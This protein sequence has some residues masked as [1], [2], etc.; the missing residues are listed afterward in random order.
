MRASRS[1]RSSRVRARAAPGASK[2]P[3]QAVPVP[4]PRP[5][6]S[7]GSAPGRHIEPFPGPW[8]TRIPDVVRALFRVGSISLRA[9]TDRGTHVRIA[10]VQIGTDPRAKGFR[11]AD[12]RVL[13]VRPR[14][15][16]IRGSA[17]PRPISL[18]RTHG[19]SPHTGLRPRKTGLA[20]GGSASRRAHKTPFHRP[21]AFPLTL[22]QAPRLLTSACPRSRGSAF[23]RVRGSPCPHRAGTGGRDRLSQ[24]RR[25][26]GPWGRARLATGSGPR[27]PQGGVPHLARSPRSPNGIIRGSVCPRVRGSACWL[28]SRRGAPE[29]SPASRSRLRARAVPE[30]PAAPWR[31][32]AHLPPFCELAPRAFARPRAHPVAPWSAASACERCSPPPRAPGRTVR[33]AGRP[34]VAAHAS[35]LAQP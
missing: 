33:V 5:R 20:S 12:E 3:T 4:G 6:G 10:V 2:P 29:T 15:G 27:P 8:R 25:T 26:A 28:R 31:I 32:P 11:P 24:G 1:C 13:G 16:P 17:Y 19:F 14:L 22:S 9:Y 7:R 23:A 30:P 21:S 35:P 18:R 34:A